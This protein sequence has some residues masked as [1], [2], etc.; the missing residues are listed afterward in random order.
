MKTLETI[1]EEEQL[2]KLLESTNKRRFIEQG[3]ANPSWVDSLL[4][5]LRKQS[6][7]DSGKD[8][9]FDLQVGKEAER[10]VDMLLTDGKKVEVKRDDWAY[11]SGNIA[12]ELAHRKGPSGLSTTEA[13]W[14]AI[15]LGGGYQSE[16][17][18]FIKTE[19]LKKLIERYGFDNHKAGKGGRSH[20]K[21]M[22]LEDVF[23]DT[24]E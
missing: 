15:V 22:K 12:I 3:L 17:M 8:F 1:Y 4:A 19:R 10:L 5:E 14:Y 20:F 16:I 7:R 21:L 18:L 24:E 6:I 9:D 23:G 2:K 13:D 11:R